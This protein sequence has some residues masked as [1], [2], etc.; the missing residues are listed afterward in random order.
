[1]TNPYYP[2][3]VMQDVIF[4]GFLYHTRIL[5]SLL[6][7]LSL[8]PIH[9]SDS[10][11]PV[12]NVSLTPIETRFSYRR[13]SF[14]EASFLES[15]FRGFPL[16]TLCL[17]SRSRWI[18]LLRPSLSLTLCL[19]SRSQWITILT[20]SLSLIVS[21]TSHTRKHSPKC[22]TSRSPTLVSLLRLHY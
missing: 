1:M 15:S 3:R 7:F 2:F 21:P 9:L 6:I 12:R 14:D 20:P 13:N 22:P 5:S 4:L 8:S 18:T 11:L 10:S 19:A 16:P 17:A